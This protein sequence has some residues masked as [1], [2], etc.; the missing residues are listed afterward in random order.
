MGIQARRWIGAFVLVLAF[1]MAAQTLFTIFTP[2]GYEMPMVPVGLAEVSQDVVICENDKCD[3]VRYDTI[4]GKPIKV[5]LTDVTIVA[6]NGT[7][8]VLA[9]GK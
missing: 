2:S 3:L 4:T 5:V 1:Y 6:E 9:R 8:V 7:V